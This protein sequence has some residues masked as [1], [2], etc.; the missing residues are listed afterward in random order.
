MAISYRTLYVVVSRS[1]L[2]LQ[3]EIICKKEHVQCMIRSRGSRDSTVAI[4]INTG[5]QVS[6]LFAEYGVYTMEYLHTNEHR[7]TLFTIHLFF[8]AIVLNPC[9]EIA[10]AVDSMYFVLRTS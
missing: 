8:L 5:V 9:Y 2:A 1:N 3:Y 7:L 6:Y 10:A 4:W